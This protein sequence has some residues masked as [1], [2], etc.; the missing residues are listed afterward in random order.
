MGRAAAEQSGAR[1]LSVA[2]FYRGGEA[3]GQP[4]P[5][6]GQSAVLVAAA[7]AVSAAAEAG[8]AE[9]LAVL[10]VEEPQWAKERGE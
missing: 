8:T 10:A 5:R 2:G 4:Q 7:A 3:A 6:G 1:E 9:R